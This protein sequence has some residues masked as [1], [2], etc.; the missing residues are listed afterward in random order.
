MPLICVLQLALCTPIARLVTNAGLT[1]VS[2]EVSGY[3]LY[4]L[5]SHVIAKTAFT[6]VSQ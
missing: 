3:I 5:F 2:Q 6:K 1:L 4:F